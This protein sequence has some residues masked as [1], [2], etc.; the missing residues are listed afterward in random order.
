MLSQKNREGTPPNDRVSHDSYGLATGR[1]VC[2]YPNPSIRRRRY[3]FVTDAA[4]RPSPPSRR[5]VGTQAGMPR[6]RH[7][8]FVAGPRADLDRHSGDSQF[9][10]CL[11]RPG[12]RE[13][14]DS[15]LDYTRAKMI[16]TERWG[17]EACA[18]NTRLS[19][20]H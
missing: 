16:V 6:N 5:D 4:Y 12:A 17:L 9:C 13:D 20:K 11:A 14:C 2:K 10:I 8:R 15:G 18:V 19:D 1:R 7:F 3:A